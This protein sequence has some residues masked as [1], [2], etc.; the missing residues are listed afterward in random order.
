MAII[1]VKVP[2]LPESVSEATLMTWHKQV[3]QAVARDENLID[4]ETDKV[5]LEL[6]A[7]LAG[8]LVKI[9]EQ[10]GATVTS[11][12]LIAHID[13]EATAGASAPAA[14]AAP[15]ATP[16]A[17]PV[18]AAVTGGA[19]MPS[20]AKLAAEISAARQKI[21]LHIHDDQCVSRT[22]FDPVASIFFHMFFDTNQ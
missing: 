16:A 4:L 8:V 5:V 11:G 22:Q 14:V 18:Q 19:A 9:I 7:P 10:D 15:A 3:G 17:A 20:A 6:P 13:T 2:Q 21:V 1:E 12:Q